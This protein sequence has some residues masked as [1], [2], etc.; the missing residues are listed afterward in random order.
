MVS[1]EASSANLPVVVVVLVVQL[2]V[3]FF[4]DTPTFW[5][6]ITTN[7]LAKEPR[8]RV[9][10]TWMWFSSWWRSLSLGGSTSH[11]SKWA[12]LEGFLH[13]DPFVVDVAGNQEL[14]QARRGSCWWK[15][16]QRGLLEAMPCPSACLEPLP[17]LTA[18]GWA[19][20]RRC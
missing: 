19:Q 18:L 3:A 12:K 14:W 5:Q 11:G 17:W 4:I 13:V 9:T 2:E 7:V 20:A 8:S 16:H 1:D 6:V 15:S 10:L